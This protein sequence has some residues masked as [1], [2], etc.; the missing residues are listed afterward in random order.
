MVATVRGAQTHKSG[1]R[2]VTHQHHRHPFHASPAFSAPF[3]GRRLASSLLV[4]GGLALFLAL[5][6]PGATAQAA[7]PTDE[8]SADKASVDEARHDERT[9]RTKDG[10]H[11]PRD[12][13][14]LEEIVVL[15][16]RVPQKLGRSGSA[17][18]VVD[19]DWIEARGVTQVS[20]L[21]RDVPGV[22]VSRTGPL[23][24]QTQVRIR[25]AE[26]NH[27]LV[28]LD[29]IEMN[30][31]VS[32]F[33]LDFAD[34][35]TTGISRIEVLRGPQSALYG[36]E[37]LGGVINI[38]TRLPEAPREL[39]LSVEGGSFGSFRIDG[40]A[41]LAGERTKAGL[42]AAFF[43]TGGVSA[44]PTGP[45]KDG[46]RNATVNAR[47]VSRPSERLEVGLVARLV[48]ARTEFDAQDFFTGAV[49]DADNVRRFTG[50]YGRGFARLSLFDGRWTHMVAADLTDTDT[51]NFSD[52]VFSGSFSGARRKVTYQ[53]SLR[54]EAGASQHR[55]TGALEYEHFDFRAEGPT[56]TSPQNQ[57]RNDRQVSFVGEYRASFADRLDLGLGVRHDVNRIFRNDTTWRTS[58]AFALSDAAVLHTSYGTGSADPTFFER[59][60]F[61]PGSFVGNP[62]VKPERGRG[63]DAGIR[64]EPVAGLY[65][66]LTGFRTILKD[67]IATVFDFATFTATVENRVGR[68]KRRGVEATLSWWP[69]ADL[70][71][72]GAYTWL[73][74]TEADGAVE[75]RRPKHVASLGGTWFFADGRGE[76]NLN[77]N[78]HGRQFDFDFSSFPAPRVPLDAYWLASATVRYRLVGS[79]WL[80][81]RAENLFDSG[82]QDVLGFNTPGIGVF[83]GLTARY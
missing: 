58:A 20:F 15:G 33:E 62:D 54:F 41:G 56:S 39:A 80:T 24:S 60:G 17:I 36:S 72:V 81:A 66:D 8:A 19:Q 78:R 71:I 43:R 11:D 73:K 77:L 7:A 18:S 45:E 83:G 67:E 63:F 69:T 14:P 46:Y 37:A 13:S 16:A 70:R 61:F 52:G 32:G 65:L 23:G 40:F 12:G 1:S 49:V 27:T 28:L 9:E 50:F 6:A 2:H 47:L 35:I 51:D 3:S 82:Y 10:R 4:G 48:D 57:K 5:C 38:V 55:I 29:G 64:L 34:L 21:L 44:S 22:E 75:V 26:G 31:P 79:L 53:T 68:S 59:F 42:S 30:D 74:A 25:G 76:A